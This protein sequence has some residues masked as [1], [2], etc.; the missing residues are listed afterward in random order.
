MCVSMCSGGETDL[1]VV[2]DALHEEVGPVDQEELLLTNGQQDSH[3]RN[4]RLQA[5]RVGR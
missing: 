4:V 3:Q 5:H 1:D 2:H